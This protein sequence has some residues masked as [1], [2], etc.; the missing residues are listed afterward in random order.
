MIRKSATQPGQA[1]GR[2]SRPSRA[3][4][5]EEKAETPSDT[6]KKEDRT[7]LTSRRT[8]ARCLGRS[9]H[10][11]LYRYM[12]RFQQVAFWVLAAVVLST[13]ITDSLNA[14]FG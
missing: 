3:A 2:R 13:L 6:A 9:V 11:H 12:D 1:D 4:R 10:Q 5:R 14:I 7:E 8:R